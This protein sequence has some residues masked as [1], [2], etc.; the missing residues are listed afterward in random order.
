MFGGVV[1]RKVSHFRRH[2]VGVPAALHKAR[3]CHSAVGA[4]GGVAETQRYL[5]AFVEPVATAHKQ[6]VDGIGGGGAVLPAVGLFL[7]KQPHPPLVEHG[8]VVVDLRKG[9]HYV[10][11]GGNVRLE[12]EVFLRPVHARL[13]VLL[14][15][16]FKRLNHQLGDVLFAVAPKQHCGLRALV[17]VER[18]PL[19]GQTAEVV[20]L[21]GDEVIVGVLRVEETEGV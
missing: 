17:E 8:N 5:L 15:A 2:L 13:L 14:G 18:S 19:L 20:V 4:Y 12:T 9:G 1:H 21:G 10:G 7:R 3:A 16:L 6:G 11:V